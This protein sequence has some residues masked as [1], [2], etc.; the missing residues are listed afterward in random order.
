MLSGRLRS[1][2]SS[3]DLRGQRLIGN[4]EN[5]VA[6]KLGDK[7]SGVGLGLLGIDIELR[8]DAVA[9]NFAQRSASVGSLKDGGCDLVQREERGIGGVHDY[10]FAGQ[11]AG[12]NGGTARNVNA[13][14]RHARVP[15]DDVRSSMQN[16][17]LR[18][19]PWH[20]DRTSGGEWE[21]GRQNRKRWR[22]GCP[23]GADPPRKKEYCASTGARP[24]R[25]TTHRRGSADPSPEKIEQQPG[26]CSSRR[27]GP[28]LRRTE[29]RKP[30][31]RRGSA[32][33]K[34]FHR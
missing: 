1:S 17:E 29:Y 26:R 5:S 2:G 34:K 32:A 3:W 4:Q 33:S 24:R 18:P 25:R 8:A 21:P 10:H 6:G 11:G 7:L 27:P 12:G 31:T 28:T 20:Q 15:L 19:T 16:C 9:D 22:T 30:R 13:V 23:P 14:F